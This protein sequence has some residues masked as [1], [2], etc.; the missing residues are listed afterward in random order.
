[1]RQ[2]AEVDGKAVWAEKDDP[3]ITRIGRIIRKLR[4]DELPQTWSVLKGEMSFVGPRPERPQFVEDLEQ[5]LNFY[6]ERHMVKPG[7]TGWAQINYPYGASIDDARQ[8]LEYDLYYAKNYSPFLDVLIL[9][10]TIRVVLWPEGRADPVPMTAVL[11][12]HALAALLFAGVALT[13]LRDAGSALPRLTFVVALGVTAL[14]ALAV[15]GDRAAR[16][17]DRGSPRARATSPGSASCSRWSAATAA[18][19]RRA[20]SRSSTASSALVVL[21]GAGLAIADETIGPR[22]RPAELGTVRAP[23][24]HHGRDQ[25]AGAGQP[26]LFGRSRRERAGSISLAV[27]ALAAMW[28]IDLLLYATTYLTGHAHSDADRRPRRRDGARRAGLR[29]RGAAQRRLDAPA[30]AHGR[31]ADPLLRRSTLLYAAG[32]ARRDQRDRGVRRRQ[33]A[34]AADRLRVRIDRGGPHHPVLA[35][36]PRLGQGEGRQAFLPPPL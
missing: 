15:A 24:A 17:G 30:L 14:W 23:A 12:S 35:L 2:D 10:Q 26:S 1:M 3:R 27:I 22:R 16:T 29:D 21:V 19:P 9:L 7:I 18:G 25:R 34:G 32:H 11:W 33:C 28:S 8:K 5:Q 13:R 31:V 6:A 20:P 4:I 36:G